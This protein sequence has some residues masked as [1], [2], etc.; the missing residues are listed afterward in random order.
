M[1]FRKSE[2]QRIK[3]D[4]PLYTASQINTELSRRWKEMSEQEKDAYR[5]VDEE[6][7]I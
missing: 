4:H 1:E 3:A 5:I 6:E 2:M 7:V